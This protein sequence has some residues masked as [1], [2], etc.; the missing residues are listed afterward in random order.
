MVVFSLL[1]CIISILWVLSYLVRWFRVTMRVRSRCVDSILFR[2]VVKLDV[3]CGVALSSVTVRSSL[4]RLVNL[5]V[6]VARIV[7]LVL[8]SMLVVLMR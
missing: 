8:I 1:R 5:D 4:C 3:V 7:S 6:T 2:L